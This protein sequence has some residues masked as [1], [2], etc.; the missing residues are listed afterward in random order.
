MKTI[1][2]ILLLLVSVFGFSQVHDP[3]KWE[4]SVTRISPDTAEVTVNAT[5]ENGWHIY[6]QSQTIENGPVATSFSFKPD[7]S[8]TLAGAAKEGT[9]ITKKE[10]AFDNM[11]VSYFEKSASFV[12]KIVTAKGK[13]FQLDIEFCQDYNL[14]RLIG[15]KSKKQKSRWKRKKLLKQELYS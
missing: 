15:Y 1:T 4:T 8:F 10:P 9:P 11:N 6:S 7:K 3:V 5:I 12:Q 2:L 13:S 14:L